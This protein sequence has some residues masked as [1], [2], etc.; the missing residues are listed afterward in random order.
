MFG[1][2]CKSWDVLL[3]INPPWPL[4][5]LSQQCAP[6]SRQTAQL[7]SYYHDMGKA[8][9]EFR[10]IPPSHARWREKQEA[11]ESRDPAPS[12]GKVALLG[13]GASPRHLP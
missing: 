12:G 7:S 4:Q 10:A 2:T 9:G 1:S 11:V 13:P 3:G 5:P 6:G 8:S